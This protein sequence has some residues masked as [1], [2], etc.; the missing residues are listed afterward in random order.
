[1]GK[2][3]APSL[4]GIHVLVVD[5]HD[6]SRYIWELA[7]EYCGAL[8]TAAKSARQAL[9]FSATVRPDIVV[10]DLAMPDE[11]GVWLAEQLRARG[12][13]MPLIA[14]SGYTAVFDDRLGT[15]LF[16][17][18]L[19]KPVDPWRLVQAIAAVADA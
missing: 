11:D 4:S 6:D 3:D 9:G 5:D 12:E 1:M 15:G 8:V 10:T 17:Q 19:Q 13:T 16:R 2:I 7:L 14:V 18:V